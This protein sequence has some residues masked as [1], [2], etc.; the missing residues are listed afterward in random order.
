MQIALIGLGR[1]GQNYN[2]VLKNA[3]I[4]IVRYDPAKGFKEDISGSDGIIISTPASTHYKL[5]KQYLEGG[6]DVLV[7]KPLTTNTEEARELIE[8]AV[9]NKRILMVGHTYLYHPAIRYIKKYLLNKPFFVSSIRTNLGPIR[10][11][12]DCVWDLAPHD[13][14]ILNYLFGKPV[15]GK[16]SGGKYLSDKLDFAIILL[17]YTKIFVQITVGWL[18]ATKERKMEI[19]T[20]KERIIFDD[21]NKEEPVRIYKKSADITEA[22]ITYRI[23]DIVSPY[24]EYKEP[25]R[26]QVT[27]FLNCIKTRKSPISDGKFGA[28]VVETIEKLR[29]I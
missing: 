23:G 18:N 5:A 16:I 12:V 25:L 7:E 2:R 24:I 6:F 4:D 11:D 21:L 3:E 9:K 15:D 22:G 10:E 1:W 8:I 14:S 29:E 26:E 28:G 20:Q 27:E 19:V 13:I 17:D